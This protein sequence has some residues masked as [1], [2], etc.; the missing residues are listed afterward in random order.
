ME[1]M[2]RPTMEYAFTSWDLY[3]VEDVKSLDKAILA[4]ITQNEPQDG[5]Q[6]LLAH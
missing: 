6:Q 4:T 3:K 1:S 2:V 5:S